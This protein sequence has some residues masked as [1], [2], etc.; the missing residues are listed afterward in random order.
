[1]IF[2]AVVEHRLIPARV[3][4]ETAR[5]KEEG[6]DFSIWAPACQDSSHVGCAGVGVVSMRGAP[7]VVAYFCHCPV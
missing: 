7:V 6:A 5:L 4:S 2:L 1:M 3:R